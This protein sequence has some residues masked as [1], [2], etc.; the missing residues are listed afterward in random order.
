ME[1]LH[2]H[3]KIPCK[4]T[5]KQHSASLISNNIGNIHPGK[6]NNENIVHNKLVTVMSGKITKDY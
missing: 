3:S 4:T 2:L 5:V 6:P 1:L